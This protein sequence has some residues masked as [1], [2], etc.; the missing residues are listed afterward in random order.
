MIMRQIEYSPLVK[1]KMARLQD[2]LS[3]EYVK[4]KADDIL[5]SMMDAVDHLRTYEYSGREI[6]KMYDIETDYWYIFTN[7]NYFIYRIEPEKVIVVQMFHERE[8]FMKTLFGL[9]GRTQESIDYW[10]E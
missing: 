7:H 9:S 1:K 6:S 8:D 10:G 2:E 4:E 3:D 5:R